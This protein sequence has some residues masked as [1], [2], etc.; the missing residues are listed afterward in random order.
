M[1]QYYD[2]TE[3]GLRRLRKYWSNQMCGSIYMYICVCT[4][5]HKYICV[6]IDVHVWMHINWSPSVLKIFAINIVSFLYFFTGL[7]FS[8]QT[9]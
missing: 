1:S 6:N 9:S 7:L 4:Y 3:K 2:S 8:K 5:L